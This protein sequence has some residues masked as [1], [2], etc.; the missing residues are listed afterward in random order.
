MHVHI[1]VCACLVKGI[2]FRTC[3]G[4]MWPIIYMKC[5]TFI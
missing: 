2:I 3:N 4:M 1:Y 5:M